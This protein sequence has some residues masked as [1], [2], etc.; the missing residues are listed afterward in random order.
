M[1]DLLTAG[2]LAILGLVAAGAL[3]SIAIEIVP[4]LFAKE[5]A[6]FN[7]HV[8]NCLK[9]IGVCIGAGCCV[10][11]VNAAVNFANSGLNLGTISLG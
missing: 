8:K 4:T 5:R 9:V 7:E 1:N 11:I 2:A 10:L 3:V 6:Q